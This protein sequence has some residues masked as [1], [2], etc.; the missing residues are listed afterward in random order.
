MKVKRHCV[1]LILYGSCERNIESVMTSSA[2]CQTRG[3][4]ATG[5]P[6]STFHKSIMI[7]QLVTFFFNDNVN[8]TTLSEQNNYMFPFFPACTWMHIV[9]EGREVLRDEILP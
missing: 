2:E 5:S 6:A 1:E 8:V 7:L 3:S 9:Y 4:N